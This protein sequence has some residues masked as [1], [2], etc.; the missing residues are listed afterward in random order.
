MTETALREKAHACID[1]LPERKLAMLS[2]LLSE[3]AENANDRPIIEPANFWERIKHKRCMRELETN[4]DSFVP[5]VSAK[6]R[7]K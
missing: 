2:P 4:P 6:S 7:K 1:A 5:F 3:L